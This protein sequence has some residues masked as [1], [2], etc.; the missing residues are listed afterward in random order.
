MKK[1]YRRNAILSTVIGNKKGTPGCL[2]FISGMIILLR[3]VSAGIES[4][5]E[6]L[7]HQ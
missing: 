5:H 6:Y 1:V 2:L 4:H 3:D 7:A